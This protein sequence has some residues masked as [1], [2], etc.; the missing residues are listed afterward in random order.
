MKI[1]GTGSALPSLVVTNEML[2]SFL[3]TNDEWITTR[4]GIKQRQIITDERLEDL[5]ASAASAALKNA[6]VDV[7]DIDFIICS[8]VLNEHVSPGL[9][10]I[11]QGLIGATCPCLD[12]N[13]ACAGFVYALDVADAYFASGRAKKIL[14]ICAEEP[15]RM[16]DWAD[17]GT[18]V[19]FGDGAG[20]VVLGEGDGVKAIKLTTKSKEE[21][22]YQKQEGSKTPFLKRGEE[23]SLMVMNG[24]DVFR[25][26]VANSFAD[27]KTVIERSNL[28]P[29]D[30]NYYLLH[31]ANI[32]IIE[33]IRSNLKQDKSKF[34]HNIEHTGNTSSA[35]VPILLDE[36]NSKGMLKKGDKL[37]FS[38]FGAGF[39]TGACLVEW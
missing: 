12:I 14:V 7:A 11:V 29:D 13:C 3:D 24:H 22:L 2:A 37:V 34:C 6:G 4:T 17:R 23:N 27:I 18:C 5:A 35:S 21:S 9:A 15:T 20:A 19:L 8:N 16:V 33:S 10:C 28:T 36:I 38:A 26:A 25:M 39:T 32:R 30:V 31:Q 1:I